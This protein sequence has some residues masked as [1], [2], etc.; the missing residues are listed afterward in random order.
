ML[1]IAEEA[2][3][4]GKRAGKG[5]GSKANPAGRGGKKVGTHATAGSAGRATGALSASRLSRNTV[6]D[7]GQAM[8]VPA[9]SCAACAHV[10]AFVGLLV[11]QG[12]RAPVAGS[13]DE[14]LM[15]RLGEV[16]QGMKED[17]MV[18][19]FREPCS[20]CRKYL[21][22]EP[23]CAPFRAGQAFQLSTAP[24]STRA[25]CR[26]VPHSGKEASPHLLQHRLA[27]SYTSVSGRNLSAHCATLMFR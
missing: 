17:F 12:K 15:A 4:A 3:Q 24:G 9:R 23:R 11:L 10:S 19:H 27:F 13:T 14:A 8:P 6:V 20:F 25:P 16:I 1:G 2:R 26:H 5:A 22:D 7:D 18:V 21:S